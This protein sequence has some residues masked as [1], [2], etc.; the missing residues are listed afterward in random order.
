MAYDNS[1]GEDGG[2]GGGYYPDAGGDATPKDS[3]EEATPEKDESKDDETMEGETA[4]LPKSI[5][6]GKTF[7][8]GD[9]VVLKIV[10]MGDDEIEVEYATAKGGG[11]DEDAEP[12]PGMDKQ[13]KTRM[14]AMGQ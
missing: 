6:A 3:A 13:G 12:A 5:L 10:H 14:A 4:L 8:P 2:Q 9:E 7:N 1:G 11:D